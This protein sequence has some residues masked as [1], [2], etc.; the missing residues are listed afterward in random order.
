MRFPGVT[1]LPADVFP[2]TVALVIGRAAI[3]PIMLVVADQVGIDA[4]LLQDFGH[5]VVEW[6]ERSPAAVQEIVSPG[7][8]FAPGRH[9]RHTPRVTVVKRHRSFCKPR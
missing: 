8:Q 4:V 7:M 2:A 1:L 6:L 3:F 5:R 9:A